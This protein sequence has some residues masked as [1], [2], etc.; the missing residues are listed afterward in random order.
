MENCQHGNFAPVEILRILPNSQ[1]GIE[2]HKCVVCAYQGGLRMGIQSTHLSEAPEFPVKCKH[3][4]TAPEYL[5][6]GL[7][8]SQAGTGRHK[9][10]VCAFHD[11]YKFG[12][13][14][15]KN[16]PAIEKSS[17]SLVT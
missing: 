7:S 2:R 15:G 3:G 5:L 6:F 10:A 12:M 17:P 16:D 14:L 13:E 4:K 1:A 8:E 9:C 11:G